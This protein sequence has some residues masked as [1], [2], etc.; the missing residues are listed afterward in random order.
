MLLMSYC[1]PVAQGRSRIFYCLAGERDKIPKK[2]QRIVDLVPSW[3]KFVNHF[4]RMDV[5]DGDNVF[6]HGVVSF[7]PE[8]A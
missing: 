8:H 1:T 4:E 5:L 3:L 6:L 2:I 7:L